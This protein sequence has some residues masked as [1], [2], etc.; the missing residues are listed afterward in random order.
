MGDASELDSPA[1]KSNVDTA[2][3]EANTG[4]LFSTV[5]AANKLKMH[6]H[7]AIAKRKKDI[8]G[9][10]LYVKPSLASNKDVHEFIVEILEQY[11][12]KIVRRGVVKYDE[13]IKSNLF[14]SQYGA[15]RDYAMITPTHVIDLS[16]V[17]KDVFEGKFGVKWDDAIDDGIVLNYSD[18][19]GKL[20]LSNA[21]LYH[22]WESATNVLRVEK[23]FYVAEISL[24]YEYQQYIVPRKPKPVAET[25]SM[26]DKYK[27]KLDPSK[28]PPIKLFIVNGFYGYMRDQ[29]TSIGSFVE[30]YALEWDSVELS[31]KSFHNDVVGNREPERAYGASIRGHFYN[32]Y[33]HYGI[34]EKDKPSVLNN[35]V[36]ASSSAFDGMFERLLWIKGSLLFTDLV[37]SKLLALR[38]NS[39]FIKH[40]LTNPVVEKKRLFLWLYRMGYDEVIVKLNELFGEPKLVSDELLNV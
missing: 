6:T 38:V 21:S 28:M 27:Q 22:L 3:I 19:T 32:N 5:L 16:R 30:Y 26:V 14:E 23:S 24:P 25:S 9:V 40:W 12:I 1:Q 8:N 15:L 31:F 37:G 33:K 11:N 29:Y 18:A 17:D 35:V 13:I 4:K 20:M 34:E 7:S 2:H 39:Q 36:H 10:V